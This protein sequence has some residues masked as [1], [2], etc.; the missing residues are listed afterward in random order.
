MS[1]LRAGAARR[2]ARL[3]CDEVDGSRVA[4]D[5]GPTPLPRFPLGLSAVIATSRA[6]RTALELAASAGLRQRPAA[7]DVRTGAR[8]G[9]GRLVR[10]LDL[11]LPVIVR[12]RLA[13]CTGLA[14]G[15]VDSMTL[16]GAGA[17]LLLLPLRADLS[18]GRRG[19][20]QA[21]WLQFCP[22]C[23][24]EERATLFPE[25]MAT[26][27]DDRLRASREP[28]A[29]PLP[30]LRTGIGAVQPGVAAT[31][32]TIAPPA[33]SISPAQRRREGRV[34]TGGVARTE[35]AAREARSP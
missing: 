24:A 34:P 31:L 35:Q 3:C 19:R 7:Q 1:R 21:A 29:R 32:R 2:S 30:G 13:R 4:G 33:A 10:Q 8:S 9:F 23:L 22:H 11:A 25:G 12:D 15:A 6:R 20:R 18:P 14:S 5:R 27:D 28:P 26:G 16:A 17:R